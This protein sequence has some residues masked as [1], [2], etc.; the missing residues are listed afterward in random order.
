MADTSYEGFFTLQWHITHRCNLRCTHC[1]QDDYS[2]FEDRS[3][4]EKIL[5]Q[6]EA[7][8]KAYRW[9]GHINFTGGEPLLHP[10]LSWLLEEARKR[11]ITTA[12]LTNG[13]LIG[14]REAKRLR[15]CGVDY[16][17]VSLDGTEQVHDAIRGKG[18]FQRAVKGIFALRSQGIFTSVSF[19]AQRENLKELPKLA[20]Y[21]DEIGANKLWY[22]RVIIPADEDENR[23]SL[24]TDDFIKL[25]RKAA[26]LNRRYRVT[27]QRALQFIPCKNKQIYRCTAGESLLT[28][29]ADGSVM[30][31]RRLPITVGSVH[32]SD[33]L[34]IY[35]TSP[36]L[37]AIRGAGL[38]EGCKGCDY[39][40]L[41]GGGAR[42]VTY[43]RTGRYDLSDPDCLFAQ[44]KR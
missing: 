29:L 35:K 28:I 20:R 23:L 42:C 40:E 38:P 8:L 27:C 12:V 25:S 32:D 37:I 43:A 16:V 21:C 9:K 44:E 19:T 14:L 15:A 26:R 4:L 24:T 39:A 1:Y 11:G 2:A 10:D 3:S 7:L 17:Q 30:A 5:D 34:T 6:Y 36:E 18:S 31:C 33:L 22:D 41:C 13:T